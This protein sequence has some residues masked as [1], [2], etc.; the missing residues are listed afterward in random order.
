MRDRTVALLLFALTLAGLGLLTHDAVFLAGNDASRFAHVQA[1][2]EEGRSDIGA[3]LYAWTSDRV[4]L[5]GREYS[6][7]PPLLAL[8]GAGVYAL[9]RAGGLSFQGT[10]AATVYLL[11]LLLA[12]LPTAILAAGFYLALGR[13]RGLGRGWRLL[14]AVATVWG[15]LLATFSTVFNNHTVAAALLFGALVAGIAGRG[16]TAGSLTA[17]AVCV[18]IVP[19]VL[20]VPAVVAAVYE[21]GGWVALRRTAVALAGGAAVFV[22]A[23][24]VTV[25]YPLPP[26]M[27]PGAVDHSSDF[28]GSVAGVLLPDSWTYPVACLL[29]S[30]GF[31]SLSPVLLFGVAGLRMAARRGGTPVPRRTALL[32]AGAAAV[33]VLGHILLVGSFGG[34][35]YGFRYLIPLVPAL[36]LFAPLAL[37]FGD[38][39]R[40]GG[41]GKGGWW[42][43]KAGSPGPWR[44]WL[45]VAATAVSVAFALIGA[46]HPWPPAYEQEA[47]MHPVASRVHNPV[48]GNLAAWAAEHLP[49]TSLAVI[50]E[51]SFIAGGARERL[52]YL[53]LFFR[54]KGDA[55]MVRK[56]AGRLRALGGDD[57]EA[58]APVVPES[59]ASGPG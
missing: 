47:L 27:V 28:A 5:D 13:Y 4:T 40:G 37:G 26:K 30:H 7:K 53:A 59:G 31:L 35:S 19:G 46:Y 24:L 22:V 44:A 6:N 41:E 32:T 42:G 55:E 21:A 17:L 48:G 25:G 51:E 20:F 49:E 56:T 38:G 33:M 12:A 57:P 39:E 23:N 34:W 52:V 54:S 43:D 11:N 50:L 9:L 15:T 14:L 3:S 45:F 8:V 1:L 36:M 2:V 29:G 18:D 10:E 58:S 16:A